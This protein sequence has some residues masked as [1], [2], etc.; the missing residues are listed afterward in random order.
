MYKTYTSCLFSSLQGIQQH[1]VRAFVLTGLGLFGLFAQSLQAQITVTA[2]GGNMN[3]NYTTL[4]DAVTAI[5][6]GVHTGTITVNVVAGHTEISDIPEI[7]FTGTAA[8]PVVIQKSGAGANPV[9]TRLTAGTVAS[10]TT[11]GSNGDGI[12]VINGGDYITFDGINVA[13]DPA[14]AGVGFMEYG[15]YLKKASGTDA[16]KNVTIK[17][18]AITLNKAAIYSFG[19][20]VSNIS[21]TATVTVTSTEGRSENIKIFNN[22]ISNAY[23]GVQLRGFASAAPYDFYDQN[24]EVGQD[25][26]N[27]ITDFGGAGSAVYGIYTIYQNNCKLNNNTI[28]GGNGTTTVLYGIFISTSNNGSYDINNNNITLTSNSTTSQLTG[29]YT[30]IGTTGNTS[31][32]VNVSGN[33]LTGFQRPGATSGVTYFIYSTSNAPF[34]FNITNNTIG[35]CSFPGTGTI[36]GI[37]QIS[38]PPNIVIDSNVISNITREST[39]STSLFYG[40]ST[41][42]SSTTHNATISNNVI[43]TLTG[44]GS[45]GAVGGISLGTINMGNVF[46]NKI[47]NITSDNASGVVYGMAVGS[48]ANANIYNNL[49]GDLKTPNTG[50]S[51]PAAPSLR[52]I[53]ITSTLANSNINLSYNT[54]FLN[55]ISAGTDFGS[56]GVFA[57]GSA[58]ATSASLTM[59]NNII[60]NG[61][62]PNG[63]GNSVAYQRSTTSLAN[64]NTASNNNMFYAGAPGTNNL[65]FF[66]GTNADQT[67]VAFKNRV[68]PAETNSVTENPTFLTTNGNSPNFLHLNAAIPTQAESGGINVAGIQ[69]DY[70]GDIRAGNPGYV[71]MGAAPDMGADEGGFIGIDLTGPSIQYTNITNSICVT[72][73]TLSATVTDAT[74]VNTAGGTKPRIWYKKSTEDNVLPASNTSASNGWKYVE[75][76]NSSSPFTFSPD[77]SLLTGAV[78]AGDVIQYFVVAQ[79]IVVPPNVGTNVAV[80]PAGYVPASVA[81]AM[82]AF[83]VSGVKSYTILASPTTLTASA[84]PDAICITGDVQL[85]LGGDPSIGAQYQWESSPAGLNMWTPIAGANM[86]S[87]TVTGITAST[88]FRCVVSCGGVPVA[89]SPSSIASVVVSSPAILTTTPGSE[90][91]PGPVSVTLGATASPGA[92]ID[93]YSAPSGGVSLGSGP[94]FVTPPLTTTTDFYVAANDGGSSANTGLPAALPTATSG[95]GTTNFGLVFDAISAFT[96]HQVTMYPVSAAANTP[97]TVTMDIV[98]GTGAILHS[99]VVDVFGN[100]ANMPVAQTVTLD[101]SIAPGTNLKLRPGARSASITGL[102]FEPSAAAPGGNYGY[103]FSVPGVVNI[104]HSTLT[105]PPANTPRLD[106]YYYF[107]NWVVTT[108]C[109]TPRVPVTATIVNDPP[110][111]PSSFSVCIDEPAFALTG[112]APAGGVYSGNGVSSGIFNPAVAGI[113]THTIT[114]TSCGLNCTFN[115]TVDALPI[116]SIAIAETSGISDNDG[117]L[118]AGASATLTA[119]GGSTYLWSTGETTTAIVVS[120]AGTYT[121]IVT[122][123]NGCTSIASAGISVNPLP[124]A[125]VTPDNITICAG[126]PVI[127]TASGGSGYL[128]APGGETTE[129]ISVNASGQYTVT[130]TDGNG[131]TDSAVATVDL[132]PSPVLSETHIEPTTCVASNGSINLIVTGGIGPF[133]YNWA[134]P[135][136]NG[137][138]QGQEDQSGLT[139]GTYIVTVT[140]ANACTATLAISLIGPGG[141]DACPV[142]GT[143]NATPGGVCVNESVTLTASNLVDMGSSFATG[144]TY[145]IYA[146][147]DQLPVDPSCRPSATVALIVVDIPSVNA[148]SSQTVCAGSNTA[149]VNFSGPVPGTNYNWT[150]DNPAIGLAAAGTGNIASFTAINNGTAPITATITVT[151]VT[152]PSTGAV[153]TG[154]SITFTIT[155]NPV[156]SV[157]AVSSPTYC[158]GAAVPSVVFTSNVPGATFAWS[159]TNE[160]IGLAPVNGVGNVPAFTA[161]N[162]TNAALTSTFTVVASYTNNGVT[163]TGTPIQFAITVNPTPTVSATPTSQ[164][165]CNGAATTA[166]NFT[167]TVGGTVFNWTN[168][169]PAIGLAAN[170]SSSSIPSFTAI[171]NGGAPV[172]ATITV[173]PTYTNNGVFCSGTPVSVTITVNPAAQVNQPAN[174]STC[175]GVLT[176]VNF[177]TTTPGTT[178]SWTNSNTAIGL[179]AS[180]TGNISFTAAVVAAATTGTITVTPNYT[181]NGVSCPG[182]PRTF[183]ILVDP[184]PT[185]NAVPNQPALCSGDATAAITFTGSIPGTVYNWTNSNPSIGLAA[186]GTGNIPSF[187]TQNVSSNIQTAIITVTPSLVTGGGSCAGTPITFTYTVYPRPLVNVGADITICENQSAFFGGCT[188]RR[189]DR[190]NVEWRRG[191]VCYSK[192]PGHDVHTCS[193]RVRDDGDADIYEQRSCGAMSVGIG[194]TSTDDQHASAGVCGQ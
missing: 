104:L 161:T 33:T 102:L 96:L 182:I 137:L 128:W 153:C 71:G 55:A 99:L 117:I 34:N 64:Y 40:I 106:L 157:N 121:V 74:G 110:S 181:N 82:D 12:I 100:P 16:C 105:A 180:G 5:N 139:V 17:N 162:A 167:G 122:G 2:T 45:T 10:S 141:C 156:P 65:I 130:V 21:G 114:Y 136:G 62:T 151:P 175:G 76:S 6:G 112:A 23:G 147:L 60:V 133:T 27:T 159:R 57:T 191:P 68:A 81:L 43:H 70:D 192:R 48:V 72:P 185:V 49:I 3:A 31:N 97:G 19:V 160:A 63:T 85:T 15:Y 118:C 140:G 109:E 20:F 4:A 47:Y 149:A 134:T 24:I 46:K 67:I 172:T 120:T 79:D 14:F 101:F 7:T 193:E 58:T 44:N 194:C 166:I 124:V 119:S 148:V 113:G 25:G 95:A 129:S 107:Y 13:T 91:G 75:A 164:T 183:T 154:Q 132:A 168:N 59:R 86:A 28:T 158:N 66:D 108:G 170:G 98:D 50:S 52:G 155:V 146:I 56:A 90:C 188:G 87:S 184:L 92:I 29:I 143:L 178:Y 116:A 9:I 171:N 18:C 80:Y 190:R 1:A 89:A 32:T 165:V 35:N 94:T 131:C 173:T 142:I 84:S 38:T 115:I 144:D 51:T 169:N 36:Y 93:W 126:S 179:A 26:G 138:V 127:L 41:T 83:P 125:V 189:R 8:N 163:C 30:T 77:Y 150:N 37:Y 176:T 111:C 61:S 54:I 88:D 152:D 39:T 11:I 186:S 187:V 123:S 135:N 103:P 174:V 177:T 145:Y 53:N 73:V 22:T 78:V 69:E 42:G